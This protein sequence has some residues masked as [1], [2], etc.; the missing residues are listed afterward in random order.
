M[1]FGTRTQWY[2]SLAVVY[3]WKKHAWDDDHKFTVEDL[4]ETL[5]AAVSLA[6]IWKGNIILAAVPGINIVEG[7]VVAGAVASY[8]I[9]GTEGVEDYI[10]FFTEPTKIPER[11]VFTA[12]TIYEHKIEKPLV[13]AARRYVGWVDRRI[14]EIEQV[15]AV[16][17]PHWNWPSVL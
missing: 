7:I 12:E 16:T 3:L 17:T 8:A 10:E 2:R 9:A 14:D 4:D 15:W 5:V 11:L 6:F 13:E 1:T